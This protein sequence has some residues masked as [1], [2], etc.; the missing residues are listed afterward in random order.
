MIKCFISG[1]NRADTPEERVRQAYARKLHT[2]YGYP[3][4]FMEVEYKIQRGS[5]KKS[6]EGIDIAIF[7]D[8]SKNQNNLY[9]AV[10]TKA[11]IIKK[12][13]DQLLSYVTATT[14]EWAVWSNGD[15]ER[16]Y[17]TNI[18]TSNV[19]IFEEIYGIPHYKQKLGAPYKNDLIDPDNLI[20][21]F[22][23]LHDYIYA[24]SNIKKPDRIT[25]NIIN[26]IFCKLDDELDID[27]YCQFYVRY[28]NQGLP[29]IKLT[30]IEI[31]ELFKK[32]KS[33]YSDI[34]YNSDS[35]EFD[36]KTITEVVARLQRYAFVNS[37]SD[38]VANAFEV[39]TS[40]S[41]KEDNGQ[42]FTPRNVVDFAVGIVNPEPE[43]KMID[44]ACGSGGFL[45]QTLKVKSI[46]LDEKLSKRL[47]ADKLMSHKKDIFKKT[48]FGFDQERDL[49]KISKAYMAIVGDGS[50]GIFSTNSLEDMS[51]WEKFGR[52]DLREN[53]FDV[54]M[55]NPPFGKDIKVVGDLLQQYEL[56]N[57]YDE[58]GLIKAK[59]NAVRPSVLF[60]ERCFQ[61]TKANTGRIA[62]VLPVGDLSNDEDKYIKQW[63]LK[64]STVE[65]VVQLPSETFQPYTG[66]QTCLLF[67]KKKQSKANYTIFMSQVEKVGKNQR[68]KPIFKR[69]DDGSLI[70]DAEG[71]QILDDQLTDILE[72]YKY[73]LDKN[74][75]PISSLSFL[76]ESNNLKNSLLPNY[77]NPRNSAKR[78]SS[79]AIEYKKLD[80]LCLDV[81]TPPRTK[82]VYVDE[83]Y[84]VPFLSGTHI[85][86]FIPQ[87]LKY[88]S[89]TETKDIKK[90]IVHEGD[91]VI[92]RVGTMGI[93][94]LIGEELDGY[95][96][97]DNI[98]IIK[99]DRT[100]VDPEYLYSVLISKFGQ[101][102]VKQVKKGSVQ[103]Y[104]TPASLK[105]IHIP[106]VPDP[107]YSEVVK[108]VKTSEKK[109]VQSVYEILKASDSLNSYFE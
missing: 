20:A 2:K 25:T 15:I 10:E 17:K 7:N 109:R 81:Y 56:S 72:E 40:E 63:I 73:F 19:N 105:N 96:V 47:T 45:M 43:H 75:L 80:E 60:I 79:L 9:I 49:V 38:N 53:N 100:K 54:V 34:F 50:G 27:D 32:V 85:T 37:K 57:H 46:K 11:P 69:N 101:N 30:A 13:D 22:Y 106:I 23:R 76:V 65:A 78:P 70:T 91:I 39:F 97:S 35:I 98:N 88:I 18:G 24:N 68:G 82:R 93:V 31:N 94:R 1:K 21:D 77:H 59:R 29:D 48:L 28:N 92:T 5:Q 6:G 3:K 84:G 51:Q 107:Q 26:M 103:D 58:S 90:Y 44:P 108:I 102:S 41:L 67:L 16:F 42:F 64:N 33:N 52:E 71:N 104:T 14:A 61:L 62:I 95:A 4:E 89:K 86:Q 74:E 99:V 55:T 8:K 83:R 66:T 87:K 12:P 36:D